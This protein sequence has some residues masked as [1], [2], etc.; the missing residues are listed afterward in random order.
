TGSESGSSLAFAPDNKTLYSC[1][2]GVIHAWDI[3]TG[4]ELRRFGPP[5]VGK[6]GQWFTW[7]ALDP[8]GSLLVSRNTA[9]DGDKFQTVATHLW[10]PKTGEHIRQLGKTERAHF[11]TLS[12][13]AVFSSD[14]RTVAAVHDDGM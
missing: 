7:I 4:R 11:G 9:L 6:G 8:D 10:N 14:G 3:A 1:G 12:Y 2:D 5:P 13:A